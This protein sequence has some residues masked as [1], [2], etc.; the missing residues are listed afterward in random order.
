MG[1]KEE[2][3]MEVVR[4]AIEAFNNQNLEEYFSYHTEDATSH[5]VYYPEPLNLRDLAE[6]VPQLWHSYPDWYIDTKAIIAVG[7][8]VAVE[9]VMT[10]TFKR[11]FG[12]QK[13]TGKSFVV[14]EGVF[15]DMKDGKIHHVRIYLD[16]KTQEEQLGI[17]SMT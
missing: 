5:E 3:N 10:A 13:A 6:F 14:R 11:D 9:N 17:A 8:K 12:D 7:D 4:K 15:F 16:Q 2:L 1:T